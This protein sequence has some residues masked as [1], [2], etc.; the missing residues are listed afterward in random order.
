MFEKPYSYEELKAKWISQ[1][2][3]A[4]SVFG[5]YF[6]TELNGEVEVTF[7]GVYDS[8]V[9]VFLRDSNFNDMDTFFSII[10]K[11]KYDVICSPIISFHKN[12]YDGI[13]IVDV[14]ASIGCAAMDLKFKFS[15][16]TIIGI[17]NSIDDFKQFTKNIKIN[18]FEKIHGMLVYTADSSVLLKIE[19]TGRQL[20]HTKN[21]FFEKTFS[22]S[23]NSQ[24]IL[25]TLSIL[26][27]Y[28]WKSIDILRIS[29]REVYNHFNTIHIKEFFL[30]T[31]CILIDISA[32]S[33]FRSRVV[34]VLSSADFQILE[35]EEVIVALSNS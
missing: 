1:M 6:K 13:R 34:E 19:R 23:S 21:F 31:K 9:C 32:N 18:N 5:G 30:I 3:F 17:V 20:I 2:S 29:E 16:S 33:S 11:R 27:V 4:F 15:D 28:K 26:K 7:N 22:Y 14:D 12:D 10:I 24:N 8:D 25:K 35:F